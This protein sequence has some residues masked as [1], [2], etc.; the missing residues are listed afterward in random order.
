[1]DL[2]QPECNFII[3][4]PVIKADAEHLLEALKAALESDCKH[5][6]C[7]QCIVN[8]TA[9]GVAVNFG[10]NSGVIAR[11]KRVTTHHRVTLH[12]P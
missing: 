5:E 6:G 2:L 8:C 7:L 11:L 10:A 4:R 12:T 9:D 3:F 1:M